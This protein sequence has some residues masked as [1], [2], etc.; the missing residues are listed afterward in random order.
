MYHNV[1]IPSWL[2][3]ILPLNYGSEVCKPGHSYGPAVRKYCLLHYVLSGEG[4]FYKDG[5]CHNVVADDIFVIRP[6]EITTYTADVNNPWYYV[7]IGFSGDDDISFLDT[8]VLS[9]LPVRGVFERIRDCSIAG[10]ADGVIFSLLFELLWT[11]S[12]FESVKY[13]NSNDY[14]KYLKL[15]MDNDYMQPISIADIAEKLHINRRYLTS[16]FHSK[17]GVSPKKYLTDLR[18]NHAR[19][20]LQQ[21]ICVSDA[22]SM[23]GYRDLPNFSKVYK[24]RYGI[25]PSDEKSEL[26]RN[27]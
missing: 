26:F 4:K 18:L 12:T 2:N 20:F 17:Y 6:G 23:S 5:I 19:A 9:G 22:A 3:H 15:Y 8:P 13:V 21:G 14:A 7:W 11:I 1:I 16:L 25:S 10:Q 24:K 27:R